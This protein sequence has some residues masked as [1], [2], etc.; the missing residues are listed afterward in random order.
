MNPAYAPEPWHDFLVAVAGAASVLIGLLFV[1]L[2]INLDRILGHPWLPRRAVV[3]LLLMFE[4]L[5]IAII[6][7]VPGQSR[8]ALGI[9]LLVIGIVWWAFTTGVF[10][11][12]RPPIDQP[13]PIQS[14]LVMAQLATLPVV[15]AAISARRRRGRALLARSGRSAAHRTGRHDV[16]GPA[17]RDSP[18][19]TGEPILGDCRDPSAPRR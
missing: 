7:L 8:R 17:D 16:V 18:V 10:A 19:R 9:E 15:V 12:R 3:A 2:S 13:L 5:V 11:L 4:A 6:G 1:S 14:N